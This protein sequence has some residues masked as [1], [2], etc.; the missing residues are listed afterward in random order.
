MQSLSKSPRSE[1]QELWKNPA[2]IQPIPLTEEEA[3]SD[4]SPLDDTFQDSL[5]NPKM[6]PLKDEPPPW[7]T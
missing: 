3:C 2:H 1:Q 6:M 7:M 4:I 5:Q